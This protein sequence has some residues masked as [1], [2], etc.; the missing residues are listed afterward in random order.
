METDET[1]QT[2]M[3]VPPSSTRVIKM[4]TARTRLDLSHAL[5]WLDLQGPGQKCSA[6]GKR[7]DLKFI[8]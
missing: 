1:A 4:L 5:V 7:E 6:A 3:S 2:S 8:A